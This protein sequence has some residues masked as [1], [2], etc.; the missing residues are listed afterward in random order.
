MRKNFALPL[1]AGQN[2]YHFG[3]CENMAI[4]QTRNNMI[5]NTSFL[6]IANFGQ[7]QIPNLLMEEKVN[8][9][10]CDRIAQQDK[11]R[12]SQNEIEVCI[13][14]KTNKPDALVRDYLNGCLLQKTV[15]CGYME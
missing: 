5:I 2:V 10:I 4:I 7:D 1:C 11:N 15:C 9:V 3:D 12:L 6:N 14:G 13:C 8:C